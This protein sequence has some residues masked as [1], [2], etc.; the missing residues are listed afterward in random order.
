M[1]EHS[2]MADLF[3]QLEKISDAHDGG[4]IVA[5]RIRLGALS[6]ITPEHLAEHFEESAKRTRTEGAKLEVTVS[7]DPADP[8]AQEIMLES[9]EI[10]S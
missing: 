7:Q 10:A 4:R 8:N 9:V 5:V 1:H 3:R 2:L 6:H